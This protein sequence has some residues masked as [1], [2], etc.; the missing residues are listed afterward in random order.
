M[1]ERARLTGTARAHRQVT[2]VGPGGVGKTRWAMA[3]AAEVRD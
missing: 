1:S 3:V 2:V